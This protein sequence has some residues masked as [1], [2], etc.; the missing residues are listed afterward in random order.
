METIYY[1]YHIPNYVQRDGSI[2]KIGVS[3]QP[4][5]RVKTQK[6][7]QYE[8][9][10][11]HTDIFKVSEREIELQKQYGYKVDLL[12]YYKTVKTAKSGR[13]GK[14]ANGKGGRNNSKENKSK[15]GKIGGKGNRQLTFDDAQTI[16]ELYSK[17]V[18]NQYQ[19]AEMYNVGRTTITQITL[20]KIYLE[21]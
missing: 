13:G 16:R 18:Y 19:L 12:P 2:G 8:I 21:R 20:N 14:V 3:E 5:I 6:H 1:I 15:A 17:K 11:T 4:E 10:E 7:S 9:L